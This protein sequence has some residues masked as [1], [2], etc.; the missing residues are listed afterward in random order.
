[1]ETL[2]EDLIYDTD[3]DSSEELKEELIQCMYYYNHQ[4]PHQGLE[5]KP[6][7]EMCAK[8]RDKS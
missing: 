8:E 3:F 4:R 2:Q 6:P 1:M 5:G 7:A